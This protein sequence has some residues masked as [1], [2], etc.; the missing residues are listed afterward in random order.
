[1]FVTNTRSY[2]PFG[3]GRGTQFHIQMQNNGRVIG[4][5]G[6]SNQYLNA[7]GVYTNQDVLQI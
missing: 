1:M 3:K 2:G 7:I 4:F 6:R 5:F